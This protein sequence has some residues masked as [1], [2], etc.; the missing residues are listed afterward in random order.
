[1]RKHGGAAAWTFRQETRLNRAVGLPG[2]LPTAEEVIAAAE[3]QKRELESLRSEC[4][5]LR[6]AVWFFTKKDPP[7]ELALPALQAL[8]DEAFRRGEAEELLS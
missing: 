4:D 7:R 1:V 3:S 2:R 5:R 6:D 8:I